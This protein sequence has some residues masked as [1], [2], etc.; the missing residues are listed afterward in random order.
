[1]AATVQFF[2]LA[3]ISLEAVIADAVEPKRQNV[4]EK[5]TDEFVHGK[6]HGLLLAVV[7]IVLESEADLVGF[8]I[9]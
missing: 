7:S 2:F 4:E 1:L 9:Q 3:A 8:D 5:A 6:G